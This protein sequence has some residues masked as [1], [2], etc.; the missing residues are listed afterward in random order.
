MILPRLRLFAGLIAGLS[1]VLL[2]EWVV[3][4]GAGPVGMA[5]GV[6]IPVHGSQPP[7]PERD[8][9][10]WATAIL[11]RPLFSI[12]R[13]PPK[14]AAGR[15]DEAGQSEARLSGILIGRF[16]RRAIFA[17]DGAG[18]PMVLAEGASVNES[19][20]QK[21]L[22]DQV[23][24]A[25]GTVLRPA[26]DHNRVPAYTPPTAFLPVAPNFQNPAFPNGGFTPPTFNAPGFNAPG[27]QPAPQN[28]ADGAAPNP[29]PPA[30]PMF[31]GPMIP[32]RRE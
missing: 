18:K 12:S 4:G 9:G 7:P 29:M 5:N 22:P 27:V 16:G 32:Q 24:L 15:H 2:L 31:R 17:P 19:T 3:P 25:S 13:R 26:F 23:I 30:P 11:A 14:L 21:I 6:L 28:D 1:L 10:G 20:I 8:A